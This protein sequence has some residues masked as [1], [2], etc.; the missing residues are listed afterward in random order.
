[1]SWQLSL[2]KCNGDKVKLEL[3]QGI[4]ASFYTLNSKMHANKSVEE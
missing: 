3:L 1:M 4:Q 2:I